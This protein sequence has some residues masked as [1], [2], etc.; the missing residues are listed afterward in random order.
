MQGVLTPEGQRALS[1]TIYYIFLPALIVTSLG[2]SATG[3]QLLSWW[4]LAANT[5]INVALGLALG[6]ALLRPLAV[7]RHL[8]RA[9]LACACVGNLGNFPLLLI[10]AIPRHAEQFAD[11]DGEQG[12]TYVLTSLFAICLA[13]FAL[14]GYILRRPAQ[15]ADGGGG[16]GGGSSAATAAEMELPDR[17]AHAEALLEAQTP[18]RWQRESSSGVSSGGE[19][20]QAR[21]NS[22]RRAGQPT[23]GACVESEGEAGWT[24]ARGVVAADA[25]EVRSTS[26]ASGGSEATAIDLRVA[27]GGSTPASARA[28]RSECSQVSRSA[29]QGDEP[30]G[31]EGVSTSGRDATATGSRWRGR[32]VRVARVLNGAV[33]NA[34]TIAV[35]I[36]IVL[37]I[38]PPIN[39]VFFGDG[40]DG[41][42][43]KPPL[44]VLT[45]AGR[46]LGAAMVPSL[47]LT[48]GASLS[49]GPDARV[50]WRTIAGLT[51]LRLV[52]L[53]V[54]GTL[55]V[56]GL[57][58]CG[59]FEPPDA[60]F[61]LVLLLQQAMPSAL[62][63]YTLAV[64]NDAFAG[65]IAT[66]LFWQYL[67]CAVTIPCCVAAFLV[68][69][70]Q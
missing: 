39:G 43:D 11:G 22:A 54:A 1:R 70:Q 4:F 7:P 2:S 8:W 34:P 36:G 53:P 14:G 6:A 51:A 42:G 46:R 19:D 57:R 49:R 48:L 63:I 47:M 29:W 55:I 35:I 60:I 26:A 40:D 23:C 66:M 59:A 16:S 3:A 20:G 64:V 67:A 44:D 52:L 41:A 68:I 28:P 17:K 10:D 65:E 5:A 62:N 25:S 21:C 13:A 15:V 45:Q 56:L 30:P 31:S 18:G 58:R 12:T 33:L 50:P 9:F 32:A 37:A 61:M 27:S 69:I 24:T 38:A